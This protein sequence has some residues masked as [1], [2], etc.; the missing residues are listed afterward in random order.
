M[1]LMIPNTLKTNLQASV[2][3]IIHIYIYVCANPVITALGE[4][5]HGNQCNYSYFNLGLVLVCIAWNNYLNTLF[6]RGDREL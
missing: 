2:S 1:F 5:V 3:Y 6:E 4:C